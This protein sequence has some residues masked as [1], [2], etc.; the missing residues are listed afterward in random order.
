M[1]VY[2]TEEVRDESKYYPRSFEDAFLF[3]NREFVINNL[4]NFSSLQNIENIGEKIVGTSEYK[5]SAYE[6]A[7]ECVKSK[8]AF[9]MDV[10][11]C[12]EANDITDFS[13]WEI[14]PYIREGLE[15]LREG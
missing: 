3:Y 7:K 1:V 11:L 13:N 8:P 12:S 15:W 5:Y 2:Q 6:L 14:P 9:S 4:D 10:L